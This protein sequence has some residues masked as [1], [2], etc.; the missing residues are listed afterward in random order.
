[1]DNYDNLVRIIDMKEIFVPCPVFD[2]N[3]PIT[4]QLAGISYCDK[5]YRIY[6][7]NSSV[8]C[9][10]YVISG[11]GTIVKD[12]PIC[13]REGDTYFLPE[14]ENHEY[15]SSEDAPWTKIWINV[16]GPLVNS[17]INTYSLCN[18]NVFRCNTEAYFKKIHNL[19]I[20]NKFT[21]KEIAAE[22]AIVFHKLI[23]T[24]AKNKNSDIDIS[25]DAAIIKNYIDKNIVKQISVDDLSKLIYKTNEHTIRIFKKAYGITPYKYHFDNKINIA[26]NMLSNTNYSVKA[27]ALT[28]NF[29]DEHY[30]SKIFKEKTGLSPSEYRFSAQSN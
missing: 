29:C 9:F 12:K 11:I 10:E 2:K 8:A 7:P 13:V 4:V 21:S 26:K 25:A 19:L 1:M 30:F 3:E 24:L 6:R 15:Y 23:Q 20:S 28:L 5:N 18:Q 14:R 17:L 22:I 27:I 16:S